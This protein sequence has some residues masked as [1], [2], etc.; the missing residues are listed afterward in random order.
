MRGVQKV[1][2][3][4]EGGSKKFDDKNFQL[5]SLPPPPKYLW[6]LPN[7][8]VIYFIS[9]FFNLFIYLFFGKCYCWV[10]RMID[11]L[12]YSSGGGVKTLVDYKINYEK[13]C[14]SLQKIW[15]DPMYLG[16]PFHLRHSD[17]ITM[18]SS[19]LRGKPF[20]CFCFCFVFNSLCFDKM[21]P[22]SHFAN[23]LTL[24]Y[25]PLWISFLF[26]TMRYSAFDINLMSITC[27][28]FVY[29]HFCL[30]LNKA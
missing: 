15:T 25:P 10:W 30:F 29:L 17:D 12:Y 22:N 7:L 11:N 3:A 24:I 1:L 26:G 2:A 18:T 27:I 6:T 23:R 28:K 13:L 19:S 16:L 4:C 5:P 21:K 8:A 14:Y 9:F 20:S